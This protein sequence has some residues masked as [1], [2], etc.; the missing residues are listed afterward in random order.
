MKALLPFETRGITK[1]RG[2]FVSDTALAQAHGGALSGMI[3]M[4]WFH[5]SF[6][7]RNGGERSRQEGGVRWHA[8]NDLQNVKVA[9][10][11]LT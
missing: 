10:R 8:R 5:P 6:L 9:L 2:E 4:P 3:V 11:R 1:A 7:L